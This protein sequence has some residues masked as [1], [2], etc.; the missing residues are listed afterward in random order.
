MIPRFSKNR[1]KHTHISSSRSLNNLDWIEHL[2]KIFAFVVKFGM[3][4]GAAILV[5]Y[6]ISIGY[7]PEGISFGDGL[8]ILVVATVYGFV[9]GL[10]AIIFVSSGLVQLKVLQNYYKLGNAQAA[11]KIG[12]L[13]IASLILWVA[14]LILFLGSRIRAIAVFIF[15]SPLIYAALWIMVHKNLNA[16]PVLALLCFVFILFLP[17][18]FPTFSSTSSQDCG[19]IPSTTKMGKELLNGVMRLLKIRQESVT[20]H[21]KKPYAALI[22]HDGIPSKSSPLGD[23]Y[24]QF[25]EAKILFSGIGKSILVSFKVTSCGIRGEYELPQD[26]IVMMR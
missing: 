7:F 21:V 23:D 3:L 25:Q 1:L 13:E 14:M 9:Y 19:Q 18:A 17:T 16:K 20:I 24:L 10:V 12:W 11:Q 4:V 5:S 15:L 6:C 2:E 26:S 8:L 22:Q